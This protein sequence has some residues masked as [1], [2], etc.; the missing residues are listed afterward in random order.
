MKKTTLAIILS[1]IFANVAFATETAPT[2]VDITINNIN[3]T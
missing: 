2:Y 1:G 3:A